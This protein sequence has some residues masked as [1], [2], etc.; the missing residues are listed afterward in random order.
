MDDVLTDDSLHVQEIL[1]AASSHDLTTLDSLVASYS[2]P[3][4]KAV[5]VQDSETGLT[6][7]HAAIAACESDEASPGNVSEVNLT[8]AALR[9]GRESRDDILS[10]A[11]QTIEFLLENGAIWN[12]LDQND[13]TPGCIA[14]RLGLKEL[15]GLMVDAGVRAEMLLNRFEEYEEL[16]DNDQNGHLEDGDET[17]DTGGALAPEPVD[18]S[19]DVVSNAPFL[20]STLALDT[21]K[22]LDEQQNGVMMVWESNIMQRSADQVLFQPDVRLLNIGFGM[23]IVDQHFQ[24]HSN[25]PSSHHI[26]EAHPGVLAIMKEKGWDQNTGVT[27]H[28]GKWQDV[29]PK[30][31]IQGLQFDAVFFDTFAESYKDFRDFFSEQVIGL[32]SDG[33]RWSFFNGMGADRQISYDV[34]QKIV[35]MDLFEAGFDVDWTEIPIPT[36]EQEWEG[37]RRRYWNVKE[38][39]LPLCKFME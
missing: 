39:R 9:D 11:K 26:V 8:A 38:Y 10:G 28:E 22:L 2:F 5:D 30:L 19:Q 4:R 27:I 25:K 7:L 32:L 23:G 16:P 18:A 20:S 35:E 37:V 14:F 6:P 17:T 33:G 31:V 1:L 13:E 3:D 21:D 36:L 15:Y 29:L 12:Q 24:A 34:Y